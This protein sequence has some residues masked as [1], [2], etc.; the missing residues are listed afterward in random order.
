MRY[1][2]VSSCHVQSENVSA[3]VF[4]RVGGGDALAGRP[5]DDAKLDLVVDLVA[6]ERNL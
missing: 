1:L 6:A 4:E 5:D 2:K 3:D